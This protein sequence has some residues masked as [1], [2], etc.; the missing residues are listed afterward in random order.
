M[1]NGNSAAVTFGLPAKL[2]LFPEKKHTNNE[3]QNSDWS[4][5]PANRLETAAENAR[6]VKKKPIHTF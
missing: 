2:R 3:E 5:L 6:T 1:E 4:T